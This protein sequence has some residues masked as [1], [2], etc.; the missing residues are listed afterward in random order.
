MKQKYI[1]YGHVSYHPTWFNEVSSYPY[2]SKPFGGLWAEREGTEHGYKEYVLQ[3]GLNANIKRSFT[4]T[5]ADNANVIYIETVDDIKN[6]FKYTMDED[7]H[8]DN[9][10][11]NLFK[12]RYFIDFE[13]AIKNGIDAIEITNIG[14]LYWPLFGWDCNCILV[15]NKEII[16]PD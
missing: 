6:N 4:F 3:S 8:D 16:V 14:N 15:M 5:L 9:G 2:W 11:L 13:D 12:G 1:H 7:E 10:M